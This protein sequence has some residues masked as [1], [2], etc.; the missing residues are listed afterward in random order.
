MSVAVTMVVE[1]AN[2][3]RELALRTGRRWLG[4][5]KRARVQFGQ[6]VCFRTG[7]DIG[8]GRTES[9][10]DSFSFLGRQLQASCQAPELWPVC[11]SQVA[12]CQAPEFRQVC[13]S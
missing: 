5:V 12:R 6:Q 8:T 4:P 7:N 10:Q 9:I 3:R 2:A 11:V 1:L 13:E